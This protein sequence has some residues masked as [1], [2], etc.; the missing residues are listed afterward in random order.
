[1]E[2]VGQ[3]PLDLREQHELLDGE[4]RLAPAGLRRP[5][6]GADDVPQV[7]V[8]RAR[9]FLCAQ[10]LDPARAVDEV[11]E[12]ELPHIPPSHDPAGD[13]ARLLRFLTGLERLSRGADGGDLDA[14]RK[15]SRQP[16]HGVRLASRVRNE[17]IVNR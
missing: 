14:V 2:G 9:A 13:A 7:E 12:D 6:F 1:V 16:A 4:R 3:R 8:D 11:E 10:E 5:A 15:P 17:I